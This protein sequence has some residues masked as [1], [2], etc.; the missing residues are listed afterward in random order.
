MLLLA[1]LACTPAVLRPAHSLPALE[2]SGNLAVLVDPGAQVNPAACARFE[3]D[4]VS[5][6][7][8]LLDVEYRLGLGAGFDLGARG[9]FPPRALS[10]K[11]S[12]LDE[13]RH[14]TPVSLALSAEG[15][16]DAAGP[17]AGLVEVTLAPFARL[18][19]LASG[20]ARFGDNVALRPAGSIGWWVEP[21]GM[22]DLHQGAGWTVGAFLPV[23]IP[24]GLALA[25]WVGGSGWFPDGR[26]AEAWVR[27]GV[28]VEPWL[29]PVGS[30]IP[31]PG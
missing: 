4:C 21:R 13:R 29:S 12:V 10:L 5:Q 28:A 31:S 15:G 30:P 24:A 17:G 23:R 2:G 11:Y 27:F 3:A 20:T 9:L 7:Q 26:P 14:R 1:A 16:V 22:G 6:T 19:A 18:D 8:A 25:P